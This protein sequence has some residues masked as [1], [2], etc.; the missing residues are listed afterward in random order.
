MFGRFLGLT[1]VIAAVSIG[2]AGVAIRAPGSDA[3]A[4]ADADADDNSNWTTQRSR[5]GGWDS[6]TSKPRL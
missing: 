2:I 3:R 6:P 5:S 4:A 1:A